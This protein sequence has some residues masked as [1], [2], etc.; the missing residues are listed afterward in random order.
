MTKDNTALLKPSNEEIANY[1][2]QWI[3]TFLKY[4]SLTSFVLSSGDC[5]FSALRKMFASDDMHNSIQEYVDSL[6]D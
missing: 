2:F 1:I 6:E 3:H 5:D 4:P